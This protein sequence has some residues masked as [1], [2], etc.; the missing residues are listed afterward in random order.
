MFQ[1]ETVKRKI[2]F[3]DERKKGTMAKLK[4]L[5]NPAC[6]PSNHIGA[7]QTVPGV[8]TWKEAVAGGKNPPGSEAISFCSRRCRRKNNRWL[9]SEFED[10]PK[11]HEKVSFLPS[12]VGFTNA[13][14]FKPLRLTAAE[15][16]SP[17]EVKPSPCHPKHW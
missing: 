8:H 16:R 7:P 2:Q 12:P 9:M 11:Q 4:T 17:S 15:Y 1:A 10:T 14:N 6:R 3:D 13:V 5:L